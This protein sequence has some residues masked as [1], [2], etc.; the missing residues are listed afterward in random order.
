[1]TCPPDVA[2]S[3]FRSWKEERTLLSVILTVPVAPGTPIIGLRLEA[4][5]AEVEGDDAVEMES[6]RG[7]LLLNLR[8]VRFLFATPEEA[9]DPEVR[10]RVT[11]RF[12]EVLEAEWPDGAGRCLFSARR[13]DTQE[14]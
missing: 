14:A 10:A 3:M 5:V 13:A 11:R 4:R 6:E 7:R 2:F 1:M 12:K 8:G 9:E